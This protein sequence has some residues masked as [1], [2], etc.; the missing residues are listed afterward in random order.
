MHSVLAHVSAVLRL[1]LFVLWTLVLLPPYLIA[2]A[3]N[4][5]YREIARFYWRTVAVYVVRVDLRVHGEIAAE[6]PLLLVCNHASYLDIIIL[7]GAI[8]AA[9]VAKAEV[10]QWPGIGF[11]AKIGRTIF[12]DRRPTAAARQGSEIA[13]RLAEG[14][15]L[16]LFPEGTSSDGNRVLPFKTSLFHVAQAPVAG[17]AVRVQPLAV[18]YTRC[19]GLPMGHGDRPFYA[20]YGDMDLVSHLWD[21]LRRPR[22]TA[23]ILF[24][25]AVSA[26]Q[27]ADRK[28]LARHCETET[29]RAFNQ[30]LTGRL[31][32]VE[33]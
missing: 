28:S 18:A 7:G 12:V 1:L 9:F 23:E 6:R 20:W 4:W 8:S 14:E 2:L 15:P 21:V 29:R 33:S 26:D 5:R 16:I 3:V 31:A 13:R 22:F 11:L 25:P 30:L 17:A 32:K 27:F 19:G 10:G 24:M